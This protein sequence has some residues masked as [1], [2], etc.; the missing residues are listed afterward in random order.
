MH[1]QKR[2][3]KL[4]TQIPHA[5]I[6]TKA[7]NRCKSKPM[8]NFVNQELLHRVTPGSIIWLPAKDHLLNGSKVDAR[9][10]VN[11]F[12][13]PAVILCVPQPLKL[14][15]LVEIAVVGPLYSC[16]LLLLTGPYR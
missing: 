16:H 9:L 5:A 14:S 15:S 10:H 4:A 6:K 1:S 3:M 12:D 8:P 2:E 13:H 11:A 7:T